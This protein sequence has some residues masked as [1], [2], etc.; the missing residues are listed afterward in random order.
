MGACEFN[1]HLSRA[2]I[3]LINLVV[4]R[5]L[6]NKP[7]RFTQQR[8]SLQGREMRFTREACRW[9]EWNHSIASHLR[10][11]WNRLQISFSSRWEGKKPR[12]EILWVSLQT[13]ERICW[14]ENFSMAAFIAGGLNIL[15]FLWS[16]S[17]FFFFFLMISKC[18]RWKNPRVQEIRCTEMI[19]FYFLKKFRNTVV[20]VGSV[21]PLML[22]LRPIYWKCWNLRMTL[23]TWGDEYRGKNSAWFKK[24]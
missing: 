16:A 22:R 8:E 18:A 24:L 20:N 12:E 15:E 9:N 3:L 5:R 21:K 1:V 6:R 4:W 14:S 2:T 17:F 11:V 7:W 19:S 10:V 13:Y 23:P